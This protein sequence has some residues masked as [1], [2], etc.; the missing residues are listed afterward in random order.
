MNLPTALCVLALLFGANPARPIPVRLEWACY[1]VQHEL[2]TNRSGWSAAAGDSAV[3]RTVPCHRDEWTAGAWTCSTSSVLVRSSL[4][5]VECL[6]EPSLADS[7][8]PLEVLGTMGYAQEDAAG[9]AAVFSLIPV[10]FVDDPRRRTL[11]RELYLLL[12]A[13]MQCQ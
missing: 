8:G 12:P 10:R 13:G 4:G 7:A 11:A 3:W 2:T 9:G 1:A 5:T 6:A